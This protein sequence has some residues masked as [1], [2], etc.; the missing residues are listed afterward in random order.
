MKCTA[1]KLLGTF[2]KVHDL[3]V[4]TWWQEFV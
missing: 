1:H 2:K 3:Y 4:V